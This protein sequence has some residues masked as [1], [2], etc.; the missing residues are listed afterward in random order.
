MLALALWSTGIASAADCHT[1]VAAASTVSA[2]QVAP[3]FQALVSCDKAQAESA[4]PTFMRA[5]GDVD[6]LVALSL[7]AIDAGVTRPVATELDSVG[8]ARG[9]VATGIGEACVDHPGVVN[10]L[11][12]TY[13]DA[14]GHG[15]AA[16]REALIACRAPAFETWLAST[17]AAPPPEIISERYGAVLGAYVR[18]AGK[19]AL[20]TLQAAAIAAAANHGPFDDIVSALIDAI[21]GTGLGANLADADRAALEASLT[22]VALASPPDQAK[23]VA[24]KLN[25]LGSD[26]AAA[27]LL[28]TVYKDRLQPDGKL[29]YGVAGLE[30]C[31]GATVVHWAP[32]ESAATHWSIQPA[33]EPLVR[34]FKPKLKCDAGTWPVLVT[35]EPLKS[36]ADAAAWADKLVADAATK[37]TASA[38]EEKPIAIP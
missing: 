37:G 8:G 14:K 6:S 9:E 32:A 21:R 13:T 30:S 19:D 36:A 22:A 23:K 5:S 35:P 10:F 11:E 27:K 26:A 18:H 3:A 15:F 25:A 38:R 28:P 16:W 1:Q 4:Y 33:A 29:L 24:E 17:A 31:D 20:P 7:A 34:A 12:T 2:D